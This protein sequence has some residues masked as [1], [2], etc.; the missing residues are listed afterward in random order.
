MNRLYRSWQQFFTWIRNDRQGGSTPEYVAVLAGALALGTILYFVLSGPAKDTLGDKIISILSGEPPSSQGA[1]EEGDKSE[2]SNQGTGSQG[3]GQSEQPS[4]GNEDEQFSC[5]EGWNA[6]LHPIECGKR[7][8]K[9]AEEIDSK[10][11]EET[12]ILE[13][14][15]IN[16][17][18][19]FTAY[20]Y[21]LNWDDVKK[22]ARDAVEDPKGYFLEVINA[23]GRKE[24]W[25]TL[26]SIDLAEL[27]NDLM[28]DPLGYAERKIEFLG[29]SWDTFME[30]PWGNL[31]ILAGEATGVFDVV[32][33]WTGE[34]PVTGEELRIPNRWG[35]LAMAL[36]APTK[37]GKAGKL[38]DESVVGFIR[39]YAC[40]KKN[41]DECSPGKDGK[42]DN[43]NEKEKPKDKPNTKFRTE[44]PKYDVK[45]RIFT[46]KNGKDKQNR[47]IK[48]AVLANGEEVKLYGS[49]HA[50]GKNKNGIPFDKDGLPDFS[51][52]LKGEVYL[53][54][55]QLKGASNTQ[56]SQATQILRDHFKENPKLKEEFLKQFDSSERAQ[57][58]ADLNKGKYKIGNYTWHH[59]QD[60]GRMQLIST[61]IHNKGKPHT[62]GHRLWGKK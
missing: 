27:W 21:C 7:A 20:W 13:N 22:D 46:I 29:E 17:T 9:K 54:P 43:G 15:Y 33:W 40:A 24:S 57:I 23:E 49:E 61:D 44:K 28:N 25:D 32:A 19:T 5:L 47:D 14:K 1:L 48:Y 16:C 37:L 6:L 45:D 50:G 38:A 8:V 36:P 26:T 53:K 18:R 4:E 51:D 31:G 56:T 62:G 60:T 52:Y 39:D 41:N 34:D 30:E 59:H 2:Q 42:D 11:R 58:E 10:Y 35:R 12:K 55:E 3:R